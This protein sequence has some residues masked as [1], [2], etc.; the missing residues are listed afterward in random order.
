M[1]IIKKILEA[2]LIYMTSATP[3]ESIQFGLR[4][5]M[6]HGHTQTEL[7]YLAGLVNPRELVTLGQ[8]TTFLWHSGTVLESTCLCSP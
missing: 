3:E 8:Q 5:K 1:V 7:K 4:Y 6:D 2:L